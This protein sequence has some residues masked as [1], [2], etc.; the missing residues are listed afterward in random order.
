M[1]KHEDLSLILKD[2]HRKHGVMNLSPQ[3]WGGGGKRNPGA[4]WPDRQ[5]KSISSRLRERPCFPSKV[6]NK[7]K[8]YS[9]LTTGLHVH[10]HKCHLQTTYKEKT[11]AGTPGW[12][13]TQC[14]QNVTF[15]TPELAFFSV[16]SEC[17]HFVGLFLTISLHKTTEQSAFAEM[18][19]ALKIIDPKLHVIP[20]YWENINWVSS[21]NYSIE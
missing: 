18:F 13:G 16:F 5:A 11:S 20:V 21:L 7:W 17:K 19:M 1:Y 14:P 3:L 10:S 2:P 6:K 15:G 8:R 4:C 9:R 12:S